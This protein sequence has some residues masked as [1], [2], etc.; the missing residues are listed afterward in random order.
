MK[1]AA[2]IFLFAVLSMLMGGAAGAVIWLVLKVMNLGIGMIWTRIPES[3]GLSGTLGYSLAVCTAGGIL[4]GLGQRRFGVM[5]EN[6]HQVMGRIKKDG[7]YPYDRL[8]II[9][10]TALLPLIFGGAVGPE[11]G[12]SGF[13]AGICTLIG[14]RL[15]Y[16]GERAAAMAE[17]GI[18]AAVGVIFGSPLFGIVGNLEPDDRREGYRE[19]LVSKKSRILIYCAGVAGGMLAMKGLGAA[20]GSSGSLPRFAREHAVGFDQWKWS[21]LLMA[22]GILAG[23]AFQLFQKLTFVAGRRM[24]NRKILSAAAAGVL[25]GVIGHFVPESMFSGEH[26]MAEL[27]E[28]WT[29]YSAWMLILAAAAK[30]LLVNVCINFGWRGGN[31][32]PMIYSGVAVGYAFALAVGMENASSALDGGFAVALTVSAMCGYIMRKPLMVTAVLLLCFPVTYIIPVAVAAFVASRVP[33]IPA[34]KEE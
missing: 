29:E 26:Q 15:K 8:H 34:L 4:I 28:K 1:K 18:A 9:A 11:A 23:I 25:L 16:K 7:G 17:A 19:K 22:A 30:M 27:I 24:Q 5:P 33:E 20:F 3:L 14:D 2:G 13:I 31:I 21:L 12:L 10:L 6:L 32:F